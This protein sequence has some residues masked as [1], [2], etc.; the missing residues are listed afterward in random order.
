MMDKREIKFTAN[1]SRTKLTDGKTCYQ[2]QI[3]HNAVLSENETKKWFAKYCQEEESRT[4]RYIDALGEFIACQIS[5][6][7]R[8]DFGSFSVGLKL[9]GGMKSAN[10][11][12]DPE[13]NSI[14]V[15]MTPGKKIRE[16][17]EALK[18]VN[19]GN[20]DHE[21]LL[22]FY[23][24]EKCEL[25]DMITQHGRRF[26][27]LTGCFPP[28][29]P[30]VADEGFWV[31]NDAGEKLLVGEITMAECCHEEGYLE[32]DINPGSYWMVLQGRYKDDPNLFRVR[33]RAMVIQ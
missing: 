11:A 33:H 30:N 16:A 9:R 6:G 10:A 29:H 7:Y 17:V 5:Q 18:P 13:V 14:K 1:E 12:F 8:L 20:K 27:R 19:S 4:T 23:Q 25:H 26:M 21:H 15:E 32:G 31:E 24:G 28:A 2:G 22:G 3:Q